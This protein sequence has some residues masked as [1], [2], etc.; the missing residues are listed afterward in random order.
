M[1][2]HARRDALRLCSLSQRAATAVQ[3]T[4]SIAARGGHGGPLG[5]AHGPATRVQPPGTATSCTR[6]FAAAADTP[7]MSATDKFLF[8]TNG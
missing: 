2:R 4:A 8:D 5:A 7:Q 1:H 6:G 3:C